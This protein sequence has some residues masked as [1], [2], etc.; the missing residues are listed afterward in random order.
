MHSSKPPETPEEVGIREYRDRTKNISADRL[1][2]YELYQLRQA[3]V[4]LSANLGKRESLIEKAL[5]EGLAAIALATSTPEDNSKDV[6]EI[7]DQITANLNASAT[8]EEEA[9]KQVR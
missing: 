5:L 1:V 3:V 2:P 8:A 7:I 9:L 4:E 6:Q